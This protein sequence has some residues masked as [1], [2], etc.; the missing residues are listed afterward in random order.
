MLEDD[1]KLDPT[2]DAD[3]FA[4]HYVFVPRLNRQ[5]NIFRES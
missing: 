5:L 3:L 1:A 2:S 4:L